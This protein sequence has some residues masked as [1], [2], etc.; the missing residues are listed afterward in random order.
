MNL[1]NVL[2]NNIDHLFNTSIVSYPNQKRIFSWYIEQGLLEVNNT[3]LFGFVIYQVTRNLQ[4]AS[5]ALT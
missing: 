5:N 4:N 1:I 2:Q 3:L